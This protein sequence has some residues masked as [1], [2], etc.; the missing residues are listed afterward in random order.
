MLTGLGISIAWAA[1]LIY[2]HVEPHVWYDKHERWVLGLCFVA[3]LIAWVPVWL[4]PFDMY[5]LK[6]REDT[7]KRCNE[8]QYSWLQFV[9]MVIYVTNFAAGYLTYDFARSYLDSG[10]FTPSR[11]V[12]DALWYV[13]QWYGV[14]AAMSHHR[15]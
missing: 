10:G 3:Y 12:K 6:A 5:G 7:G 9:W 15:V 8:V 14:A 2:A 1:N 4:L 13:M 11:K